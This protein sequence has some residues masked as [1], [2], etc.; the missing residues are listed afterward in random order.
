[1]FLH[2]TLDLT[3]SRELRANGESLRIRPMV[4]VTMTARAGLLPA[5]RRNVPRD[6][7]I[8]TTSMFPIK[9]VFHKI[10]T[11]LATTII[12]TTM[13]LIALHRLPLV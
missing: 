9:L 7:N 11:M 10:L 8:T 12:T 13:L 5:A 4:Q 6:T 3:L 2:P 1:M